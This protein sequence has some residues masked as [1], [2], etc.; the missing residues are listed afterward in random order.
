MREL[1]VLKDESLG[2]QFY[3][4]AF[5]N[6]ST[7]L[8][9]MG[10]SFVDNIQACQSWRPSLLDVLERSRHSQSKDPRDRVYAF[11]NLSKELSERDL[12][13]DYH[14]TVRDTYAKA[15]R[16]FVRAGQGPKLICNAGLSKSTL[17]LPSWIPDWSLNELS[18]ESIAPQAS[19]LQKSNGAPQAGGEYEESDFVLDGENSVRV[20]AYVIGQI[21]SLG[22]IH[23]FR[24]DPDP[25]TVAE[26]YMAVSL[27]E[28]KSSTSQTNSRMVTDVS[29]LLG[30]FGFPYETP[31]VLGTNNEAVSSDFPVL[32][33]Y[34]SEI[35]NLAM[36]S[37]AYGQ[38]FIDVIWRTATCDREV[39]SDNRAPVT[40][41]DYFFAY[42]EEV[43]FEYMPG[44]KEKR[45]MELARM[46]RFRQLSNG[47]RLEDSLKRDRW[48]T[49]NLLRQI[50]RED[51]MSH[52]ESIAQAVT[53]EVEKM[54]RES[55]LLQRA[56][57]RFCFQLRAA[58]TDNGRVGVVPHKAKAGDI[59]VIIK[60]VCVPM[61]LRK[62][63]ESDNQYLVVGQ[64]YF[65]GFMYG[66]VFQ[67]DDIREQ[68][69]T[70]V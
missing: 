2:I 1:G 23:R 13:P 10:Q 6:S 5:E 64:A 22:K 65:R 55:A 7:A 38:D 3:H 61:I 49:L 50:L 37:P 39:L 16:F 42:M 59:V 18:F 31:L 62:I 33:R 58:G 40:Y 60:G 28:S 66:E 47:E 15:G 27:D 34:V 21:S 41:K 51:L 25:D 67:S 20:K 45:L 46:A 8:M 19:I 54:Q 56:V 4:P 32:S 14:A 30:Y 11:L 63:E 57:R 35:A 53:A 9:L 48:S 69:I 12:Q 52:A 44:Q 17:G 68:T 29:E 26:R 36:A 24:S 70:L 43:R